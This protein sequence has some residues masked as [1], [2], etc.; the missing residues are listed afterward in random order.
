VITTYSWGPFGVGLLPVCL[1]AWGTPSPDSRAVVQA[2]GCDPTGVAAREDRR[3]QEP[4]E[5]VRRCAQRALHASR[6]RRAT[7][8][9]RFID[10]C[11]LTK[12]PD[13]ICDLVSISSL[14]A[15]PSVAFG[16]QSGQ[17]R[18]LLQGRVGEC[19]HGNTDVRVQDGPDVAVRAVI[20]VE[21][22]VAAPSE[23]W[24]RRNAERNELPALPDLASCPRLLYVCVRCSL[25]LVTCR[26]AA[27]ALLWF[28]AGSS[29]TTASKSFPDF[30][31]RCS[32]C[33]KA[34]R[35]RQA[36]PRPCARAAYT[37]GE[38]PRVA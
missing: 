2:S 4:E 29:A 37:V 25:L 12:L 5:P 31:P 23:R 24:F 19:P 20:I 38:C 15:R 30:R 17:A 33:A 27:E 36:V 13:S 34:R 1:R 21:A 26:Y 35:R 6:P 18:P 28:A 10:R 11:N 14:Y 8:R 9:H 16:V 22:C 7:V 3:A 32:G